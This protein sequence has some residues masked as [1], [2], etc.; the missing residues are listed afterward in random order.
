MLENRRLKG[1]RVGIA[2]R[3]PV[4]SEHAH[5]R[6]S[7]VSCTSAR[8]SRAREA[9]LLLNNKESKRRQP[10]QNAVRLNWLKHLAD[11]ASRNPYQGR[12]LAIG[13]RLPIHCCP[14]QQCP[15]LASSFRSSHLCKVPQFRSRTSN[16]LRFSG[17][18]T[19]A[20]N[21]TWTDA[22]RVTVCLRLRS[23]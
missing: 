20:T 23:R 21:G 11:A 1:V 15:D 16:G 4:L 7:E 5:L 14:S 9:G 8:E 2:P 17:D 19:Q 3:Q 22:T 13:E 6:T 12:N 18:S 10:V